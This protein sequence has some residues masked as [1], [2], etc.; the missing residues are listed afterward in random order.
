MIE[1]AQR[2]KRFDHFQQKKVSLYRS[3]LTMI[4]LLACSF[5]LFASYSHSCCGIVESRC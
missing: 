4:A 5:S 3:P 1:G 2:E